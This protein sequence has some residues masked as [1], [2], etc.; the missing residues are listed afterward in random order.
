M[1]LLL[2]KRPNDCWSLKRHPGNCWSSEGFFLPCYFCWTFLY[3]QRGTWSVRCGPVTWKMQDLSWSF[4]LRVSRSH[5]VTWRFFLNYVCSPID[6]TKY[7]NQ[8]A[9]KIV[10]TVFDLSQFF[11]CL[12]QMVKTEITPQLCKA[13]VNVNL[14]WLKVLAKINYSRGICMP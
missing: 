7:G 3:E 11:W 12:W 1:A 4:L 2:D 6:T 14:K 10:S 5:S 13:E 9:L 8:S